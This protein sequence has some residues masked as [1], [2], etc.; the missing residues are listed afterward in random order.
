M[1]KHGGVVALA[2]AGG[3]WCSCVGAAEGAIGD[4]TAWTLVEDPADPNFSASATSTSATLGAG[5]GAVPLATDIGFQSV[6]GA[7]VGGS[8]V[9]FAFS[10]ASDFAVA[11]DFDASFVTGAGILSLGFG[12]GVDG[13]GAD[14]AGVAMATQNGAP[15]AAFGG[16]ARVGDVDQT[17]IVLAVGAS[18]SGSMFVS[19]DAS[20]GDVTVGAS[21]TPGAASASSSGT[22]AGIAQQWSAGDLLASFFIRS[23]P[24]IGWQGG[25]ASVVF[26]NLRVTSGSAFEVPAPGGALVALVASAGAMRRRR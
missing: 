23:G 17:P 25:D 12:V 6:D 1:S 21:Q 24:T 14:S 2:C 19:Y 4:F 9:G 11:I 13:A 16:A 15:L 20:S 22:F 10:A 8:S 7:T 3:L 26:S 18:L 5:A